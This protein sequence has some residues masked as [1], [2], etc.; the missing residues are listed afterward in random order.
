MSLQK[1]V[2]E[3]NSA[4]ITQ[5][6]YP[7]EQ[8]FPSHIQSELDQL[9]TVAQ[10]LDVAKHRWYETSTTV[11]KHLEGF[12]G[13]RYVTDLFSESSSMEDIFWTLRAFEMEQVMEPTYKICKDGI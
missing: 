7:D 12:I 9:E 1:L 2:A 3:I 5:A 11:Y 13:I 8:E 10:G 6:E 4:Q